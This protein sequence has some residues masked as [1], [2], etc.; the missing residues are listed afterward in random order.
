MAPGPTRGR[1]AE[2][3]TE[4]AAT[5]A[6]D[7]G[8]RPRRGGLH[9]RRH[10]GDAAAG[11]ARGRDPVGS[12]RPMGARKPG[13]ARAWPMRSCAAPSRPIDAGAADLPARPPRLPRDQSC[14]KCGV[15]G[16]RWWSAPACRFS[17]GVSPGHVEPSRGTLFPRLH[18]PEDARLSPLESLFRRLRGERKVLG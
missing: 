12:L 17:A 7:P 15:R 3:A 1:K 2:A 18:G 11:G 9:G 14:G 16:S 4:A 8:G 10:S 6:G 13:G 5:A